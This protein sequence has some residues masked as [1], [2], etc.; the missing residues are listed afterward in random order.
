MTDTEHQ[1]EL[2]Y[3]MNH[4]GDEIMRFCTLQ[5]KDCLRK[6]KSYCC[7]IIITT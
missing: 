4:Y 7:S 2:E 6:T 5:L 1:E 3:L